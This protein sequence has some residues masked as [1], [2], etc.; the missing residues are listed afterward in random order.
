MKVDEHLLVA[1]AGVNLAFH[2]IELEVS[3]KDAG[4]AGGVLAPGA[5]VGFDR[6]VAEKLQPPPELNPRREIGA[7]SPG[8]ARGPRV[9]LPVR[10][11]AVSTAT[12]ASPIPSRR[13]AGPSRPSP[14]RSGSEGRDP[15][16]AS[17]PEHSALDS[18]T[19]EEQLFN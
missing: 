14:G 7:R 18:P 12:R 10:G 6:A 16:P 19:P 11:R 17:G 2:E 15:R 8:G 4:S 9:Q 1:A 5:M 3:G 13:P